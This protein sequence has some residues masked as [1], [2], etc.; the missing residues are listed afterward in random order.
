MHAIHLHQAT[1]ARPSAGV[2]EHLRY[3]WSGPHCIVMTRTDSRVRE[4]RSGHVHTLIRQQVRPGPGAG[5]P[6]RRYPD[7]LG[8]MIVRVSPRARYGVGE[9]VEKTPAGPFPT[10]SAEPRPGTGQGLRGGAGAR[11]QRPASAAKGAAV[12]AGRRR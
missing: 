5:Y 12:P 3:H 9:H 7:H 6:G 11:T 4:G 8:R 1:G 10:L 2:W